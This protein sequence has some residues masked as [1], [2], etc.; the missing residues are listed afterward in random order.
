MHSCGNTDWILTPTG[1]VTVSVF[2]LEFVPEKVDS[3]E[4][5]SSDSLLTPSDSL[6]T[7]RPRGTRYL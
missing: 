6:L 4:A 1:G 3:K 7:D 5:D 2:L